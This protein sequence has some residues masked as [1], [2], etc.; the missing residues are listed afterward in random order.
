MLLLLKVSLAGHCPDPEPPDSTHPHDKQ[1]QAPG[2]L[3]LLAVA[4]QTSG[5]MGEIPFPLEQ[6]C[7]ER[8]F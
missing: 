6:S 4:A 5:G 1:A 7:V 8:R 2:S 3:G